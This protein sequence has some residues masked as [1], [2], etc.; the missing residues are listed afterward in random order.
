MTSNRKSDWLFRLYAIIFIIYML[1]FVGNGL[2]VVALCR[3][4]GGTGELMDPIG[5]AAAAWLIGFVIP[6][7]PGGI[8]V[9][10]A[11]LIAGLSAAGMPATEA[12]AVALGHRFVTMIGDALVAAVVM[13]IEI[14]K[15]V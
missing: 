15:V 3:S 4:V 7:A 11:F 9:R 14:R 10:D 1:F 2:I 5:V 12:S 8:G 13:L 6:G